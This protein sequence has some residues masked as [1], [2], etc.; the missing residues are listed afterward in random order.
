MRP[1]W[2]RWA[3]AS[4]S[5]HNDY[6]SYTVSHGHFSIWISIITL[7]ITLNSF[8]FILCNPQRFN[9]LPLCHFNGSHQIITIL[10]CIYKQ[11][12]LP[13]T[14]S[15]NFLHLLWQFRHILILLLFNVWYFYTVTLIK[16]C[17][18]T[19]KGLLLVTVTPFNAFPSVYPALCYLAWIR[20]TAFSC[21]WG[22]RFRIP[23]NATAQKRL[24]PDCQLLRRSGL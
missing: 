19:L 23:S 22:F 13:V 14:V 5:P 21:N 18:V 17:T 8:Y 12:I 24:L 15:D 11:G 16:F 9:P 2:L 6:F 10:L 20:H 4:G 3:F 1:E 7:F